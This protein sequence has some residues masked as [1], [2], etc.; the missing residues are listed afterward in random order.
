M[1]LRF[2]RHNDI[3]G[4]ALD[5]D[6]VSLFARTTQLPTPGAP[7]LARGRAR[8][9][10]RLA[11]EPPANRRRLG[12][13]LALGT[14]GGG[15]LWAA[16][17][18]TASA[19][20]VTSAA[21]GL[22][23]LLAGGVAT[24]EVTGVGPSVFEAIGLERPVLHSRAVETDDAGDLPGQFLTRLHANGSFQLRGQLVQVNGTALIVTTA[25][26]RVD[27]DVTNAEI[28]LPGRAAVISNGDLADFEGHLI[29]VTGAC[30]PID[31][32]A[33]DTCTVERV[34]VLG[35]AGQGAPDETG[36]TRGHG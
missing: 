10:R 33:T 30:D 3:E 21:V 32:F 9:A 19:N 15:G 12:R 2:W 1:R 17:L 26:G 31:H 6:L 16:F 14:A 27:L 20:K 13:R 29:F 35:Q 5:P 18:A 24:T 36:K 23:V 11:V 22:S 4:E 34:T 25:T 7:E 8:V 28:K